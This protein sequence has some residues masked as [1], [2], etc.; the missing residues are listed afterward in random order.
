VSDTT[1]A[2]WAIVEIMGHKRYV[3]LVSEVMRFGITMLHIEAVVGSDLNV[4][5]VHLHP[6]TSLFGLHPLTEEEARAEVAPPEWETRPQLPA[7]APRL[8]VDGDFDDDTPIVRVAGVA[9][10]ALFAGAESEVPAFVA[11]FAGCEGKVMAER[12]ATFSETGNENHVS[13]VPDPDIS[14]AFLSASGG[15]HVVNRIDDADAIGALGAL[16]ERFNV[17]ESEWVED[18]DPPDSVDPK[19][20]PAEDEDEGH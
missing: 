15:I 18:D 14:P 4:R 2:T 20:L 11:F 19:D 16:A 7:A 12:V 8:A 3:A 6:A 9:G 17:D 13:L 5:K 1:G 10:W